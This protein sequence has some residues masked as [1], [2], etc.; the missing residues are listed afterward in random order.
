[1]AFK[2]PLGF[3]RVNPRNRQNSVVFPV[4]QVSQSKT[5]LVFLLVPALEPP[6]SM[7]GGLG[8]RF[9]PGPRKAHVVRKTADQRKKLPT[10]EEPWFDDPMIWDLQ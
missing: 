2:P 8:D 4:P 3:F 6:G 10:V 7:A 1:M 5:V 9:P